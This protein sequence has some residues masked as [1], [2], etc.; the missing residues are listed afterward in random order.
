MPVITCQAHHREHLFFFGNLMEQI[1]GLVFTAIVDKHD[2]TAFGYLSFLLQAL[3]LVPHDA[4]GFLHHFFFVIARYY[5]IK[6]RYLPL[7]HFIHVYPCSFHGMRI[8]T[9]TNLR[10]KV[11]DLQPYFS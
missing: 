2:L 4:G 6:Y 5:K 7:F 8:C 11:P 1:Q 10:L 3:Y 9:Y